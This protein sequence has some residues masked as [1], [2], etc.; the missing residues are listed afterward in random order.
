MHND[1]I[2]LQYHDKNTVPC[3]KCQC[4]SALFPISFKTLCSYVS[5]GPVVELFIVTLVNSSLLPFQLSLQLFI[6]VA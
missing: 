1:L 6:T 5:A 3:M 4:R 2:I